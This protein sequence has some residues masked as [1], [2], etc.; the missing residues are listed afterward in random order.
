M[1][2]TM[3]SVYIIIEYALMIVMKQNVYS[4]IFVM[5]TKQ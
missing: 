2:M 5:G 1:Q 4:R 3:N